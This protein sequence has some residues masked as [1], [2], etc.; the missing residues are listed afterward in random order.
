MNV[1]TSENRVMSDYGSHI[2]KSKISHKKAKD[3]QT[4]MMRYLKSENPTSLFTVKVKGMQKYL[5]KRK[6]DSGE[7]G[8]GE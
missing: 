1:F 4:L 8:K 3:F 7:M 2:W 5:K 6:K